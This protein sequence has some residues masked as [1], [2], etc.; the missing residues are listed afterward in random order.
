MGDFGPR[1]GQ[2]AIITL[3]QLFRSLNREGL[4]R[5]L[6]IEARRGAGGCAGRSRC[7]GGKFTEDEK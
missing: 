5:I 4:L 3:L 7:L 2:G 6:D 1:L